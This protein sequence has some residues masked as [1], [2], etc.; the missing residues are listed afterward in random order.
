MAMIQEY[1]RIEKE[2]QDKYGEKT[3]LLYQVGS[4]FEVYGI[5]NKREKHCKS[6]SEMCNLNLS[7]KQE[8]SIW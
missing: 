1:F 7:I 2:Y 5:Q 8:I 4:F 3:F 6:F